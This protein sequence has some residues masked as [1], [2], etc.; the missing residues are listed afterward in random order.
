MSL[1]VLASPQR[2]AALVDDGEK[3]R[4]VKRLRGDDADAI[5]KRVTV[6]SGISSAQ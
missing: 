6:S 1:K 2:V 4:R 5:S 3:A